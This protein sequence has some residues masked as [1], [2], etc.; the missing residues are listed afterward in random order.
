MRRSKRLNTVLMIGVVVPFIMAVLGGPCTRSVTIEPAPRGEPL[1]WAT[2]VTDA[3]LAGSVYAIGVEVAGAGFAQEDAGE[4]SGGL[5]SGFVFIGTGFAAH[6]PDTI[7]TNAHVAEAVRDAMGVVEDTDGN[8]TVT[9]IPVAVRSGTAIGGA[10]TH[11]LNMDT[12]RI[13]PEYDPEL[14]NSPDLAMFHLDDGA[15]RDVPSLLPRD[16]ATGL[17]VGAAGRYLGVSR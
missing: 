12:V 2:V 3:N 16:L 5:G 11:R 15:F 1:N 17:Q 6:Y 7:W 9:G 13:H 8:V 14:L 10:H 4:D